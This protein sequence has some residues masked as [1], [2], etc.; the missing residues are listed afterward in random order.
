M[1]LDHVYG[2]KQAAIC[3]GAYREGPAAP[4][5]RSAIYLQRGVPDAKQWALCLGYITEQHWTLLYLIPWYAP[6][7]AVT[8]IRAD[9]IDTVVCAAGTKPAHQ[10]AN[11]V[12]PAGRVVYVHPHPTVMEPYHRRAR[13]VDDLILRWSADGQDVDEIARLTGEDTTNIEALLRRAGK[14]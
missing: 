14:H 7:D 11:D 5:T 9:V 4:V 3:R 2:A 8:L 13:T 12:G 10:L 1:D 6:H